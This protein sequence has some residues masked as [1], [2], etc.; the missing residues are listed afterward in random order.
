MDKEKVLKMSEKEV[1]DIIMKERKCPFCE[2]RLDEDSIG[3][4]EHGDITYKVFID[5]DNLDYQQDET[6]SDYSDFYCRE[7]G[8]TIPYIGEEDVFELLKSE[9]GK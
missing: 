9:E 5:H 3:F 8:E 6:Y 2:A 1:M 7:C 4:C